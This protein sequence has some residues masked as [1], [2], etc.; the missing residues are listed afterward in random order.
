MNKK[1]V[2][3]RTVTFLIAVIII[4]I[5]LIIFYVWQ[6]MEGKK[7]EGKIE[8]ASETVHKNH[9]LID[10]LNHPI[11]SETTI[12]DAIAQDELD[13]ACD[14]A[15]KVIGLLYGAQKQ[16]SLE[17]DGDEFCE[18]AVSPSKA[19]KLTAVIPTFDKEVK[20]VTLEI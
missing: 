5:L 14:E 3:F 10:L 8:V 12:G 19:T 6:G 7:V 1:A 4:A 13:K 2:D 20:E 15:K 17:F 16:F 11:G 18:S 9:I